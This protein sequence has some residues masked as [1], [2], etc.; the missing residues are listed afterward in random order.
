M[1]KRMLALLL[2]AAM[3]M[4]LNACGADTEQETGDSVQT[5]NTQSADMQT[6]I[7]QAVDPLRSVTAEALAEQTGIVL[8]AP[9]GAEQVNYSVITVGGET[10]I[11]QMDLTWDGKEGFLRAQST[12]LLDPGDISGLYYT[13]DTIT[14]EQVGYCDALLCLTDGVG[15][16]A[17]VDPAA[18]IL[19]NLGMTGGADAE[20]LLQLANAVFDLAQGDTGEEDPYHGLILMYTAGLEQGWGPGDFASHNMSYMAGLETAA[21]L[22]YTKT[23]LDG[24]GVEELIVANGR[25]VYDLYTVRDE[26][27]ILLLSGGERDSYSL[28]ADNIIINNG[29]NSAYSGFT[30]FFRLQD[31]HLEPIQFVGF[32]AQWNEAEPWFKSAG[33]AMPEDGTP[34]SEEEALAIIASYPAVELELTPLQS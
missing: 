19:Y 28:T 14:Q 15:Y 22:G 6:G 34:I 5:E 18:G 8:T 25:V 10:P 4:A 11:A 26:E 33:W 2:A 17:W 20:T 24:N 21:G 12:D 31:D 3:V 32:D 13:W 30:E 7:T 9:V 16:I 1:M 27:V 29:S 23:D